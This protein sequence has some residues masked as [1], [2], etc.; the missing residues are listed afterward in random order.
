MQITHD[1]LCVRCNH[2]IEGERIKVLPETHICS[3]CAR[4]TAVAKNKGYMAYNDKTGADVQVVSPDEFAVYRKYQ[5]YGRYT[6]RGSGVHA[7]SRPIVKL[8]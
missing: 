8:G 1:T 4:R 5:P 7:M 6:G 3:V 2:L